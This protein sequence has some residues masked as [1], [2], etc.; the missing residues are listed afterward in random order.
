MRANYWMPARLDSTF[1]GRDANNWVAARVGVCERGVVAS[2]ITAQER[3]T[4]LS[5]TPGGR[6]RRF[7]TAEQAKTLADRLNAQEG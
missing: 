1:A 7:A 2:D 6:L 5:R 4:M 3:K